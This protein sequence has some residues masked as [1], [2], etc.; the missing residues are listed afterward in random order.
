M[1]EVV[2]AEAFRRIDWPGA[3]RTCLT[4]HCAWR[5]A[6]G[7]DVRVGRWCDNVACR[8]KVRGR[9]MMLASQALTFALWVDFMID[10]GETNTHASAWGMLRDTPVPVFDHESKTVSLGG[11]F[12]GASFGEYVEL[13]RTSSTECR[14]A[15]D[16][17]MKADAPVPVFTPYARTV[18]LGEPAS[19]FSFFPADPTTA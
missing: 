13:L 8:Y 4:N 6:F 19:S 10:C 9:E 11:R 7:E 16:W 5:G 14:Y 17:E 1:A 12:K 15:S 2:E 3:T 18:H